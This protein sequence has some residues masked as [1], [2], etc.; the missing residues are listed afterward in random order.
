MSLSFLSVVPKLLPRQL[1]VRNSLGQLG[2]DRQAGHCN[3]E[4]ITALRLVTGARGDFSAQP[5]RLMS[6]IPTVDNSG[7]LR[8]STAA[9]YEP[10][11]GAGSCNMSLLRTWISRTRTTCHYGQEGA[12]WSSIRKT[13]G[14]ALGAMNTT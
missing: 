10:G 4:R 8:R 5:S 11:S 6:P 14:S 12:S 9:G 2:V 3:A 13:G 1:G 7:K